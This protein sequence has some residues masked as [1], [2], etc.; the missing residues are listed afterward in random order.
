MWHLNFTL[1]CVGAAEPRL[2]CW[3]GGC[4]KAHDTT[5]LCQWMLSVVS[6]LRDGH[7]S[8]LK[9]AHEWKQTVDFAVSVLFCHALT[10]NPTLRKLLLMVWHFTLDVASC[11]SVFHDFRNKKALATEKPGCYMCSEL[12]TV[13]RN[14]A[15]CKPSYE[16]CFVYKRVHAC[17]WHVLVYLGGH[18]CSQQ[19]LCFPF[20]ETLQDQAE[21]AHATRN[22]VP[23]AAK[24]V[25]PLDQ[26]LTQFTCWI[27]SA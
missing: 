18:Q 4:G 19:L 17:T 2:Q 3:P 9:N 20:L 21:I 10:S 13:H 15:A 11:G 23:V 14:M 5:V 26:P 22:T 1:T 12:P 8:E 7:D 16:R 27:A 25:S 6:Q 24:F